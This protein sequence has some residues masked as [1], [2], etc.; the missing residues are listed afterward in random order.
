MFLVFVYLQV[1]NYS[2]SMLVRIF[3]FECSMQSINGT[4]RAEKNF[5]FKSIQKKSVVEEQRQ[6]LLAN[7]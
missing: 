3:H 7:P 2:L 4:Y 6:Q 1:Y 5:K